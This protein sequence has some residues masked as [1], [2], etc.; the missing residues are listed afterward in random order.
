MASVPSRPARWPEVITV[1][2]SEVEELKQTP[3][4]TLVLRMKGGRALILDPRVAHLITYVQQKSRR[5]QEGLRD[6]PGAALDHDR[7][8][9]GNVPASPSWW[10][11]LA[12]VLGR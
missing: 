12:R 11:R 6:A 4:G 1:M 5:Q 3:A 7:D 8:A 10:S 9:A 2:P